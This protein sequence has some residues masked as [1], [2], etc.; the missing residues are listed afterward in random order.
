MGDMKRQL[1]NSR[2]DKQLKQDL[3]QESSYYSKAVVSSFNHYIYYNVYCYYCGVFIEK[4]MCTKFR[5]LCE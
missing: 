4:Y 2:G 1:Q 5:L 3:T